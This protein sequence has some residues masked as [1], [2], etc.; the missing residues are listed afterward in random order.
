M[1]TNIFGLIYAAEQQDSAMRD[2]VKQRS[3][4]ALPIGG[5]YR[6]IDFILSNMVNTGIRNVGVIPR[7]NYQSLMDHLGSGKEW[8]LSRKTDGLFILPPYDTYENTGSYHGLIDT[9]KGATAYVRRAK[10]EYC[11]IST[12]S[13]VYNTK[14]NN[15]MKQHIA[16]GA[17]IT[18]MYNVEKAGKTAGITALQMDETGRVVDFA[19]VPTMQEGDVNACMECF[20]VKKDFL[21]NLVENAYNRREYR[22]MEDVLQNR[23]GEIKVYGYKFEGHVQRYTD[24]RGFFA[25]NME[26]L[27]PSVQD[28]L[29]YSHPVYT[30]AKD[31]APT[32]YIGDAKVK[33][34]L[35]GSGCLI[36][37][38]LENCIVFRNVKIHAGAKLKN[39]IV[40]QGTEVFDGACVDSVILDK[41]VS[42]RPGANLVGHKDYPIVIPKGGIV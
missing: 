15:M 16:T 5:R 35:I 39:C 41:N 33:N 6:V 2:L 4:S 20:L 36:E 38:E 7:K 13:L 27:C 40:M 23:L 19:P 18:I 1:Q 8:D 14:Y 3:V 17:D 42:V 11:L 32:K 37:G 31:G 25:N 9:I 22:L 30:K 26:M 29:F 21:I 24:V 28:N 34:S 10:Q 12:S